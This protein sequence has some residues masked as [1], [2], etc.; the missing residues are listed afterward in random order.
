M[1][2]FT[3]IDEYITTFP[4]DVQ[5]RLEKFRRIIHETAP[6][7]TEAISYAMPTFKLNGKNLIHFAAF[8]KHVGLYP[9]PHTIEAFKDDLVEYKHAKGSIQFPLD[10]PIPEE[11][12]RKIVLF[13]I[14]DIDKK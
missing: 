4:A 6:E 2:R 1:S 9:L 14:G 3:T 11:L 8:P 13:R 7:A 12:I 10:Q 5:T